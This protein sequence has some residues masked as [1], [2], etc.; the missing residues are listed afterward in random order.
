MIGGIC[1]NK[2]LDGTVK[3]IKLCQNILLPP[4]PPSPIAIIAPAHLHVTL[5][6]PI[7]PSS[8]FYPVSHRLGAC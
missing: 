5:Y 3:S 4:P 8:L 1:S 6:C 7:S 2:M